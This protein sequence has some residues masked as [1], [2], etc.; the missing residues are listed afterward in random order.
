MTPT[1][2]T[3]RVLEIQRMSTEDGP[4]IRTTVF[5]KGCP[6]ACAW[7]HNPESIDPRPQIQWVESKCIGCKLCLAVCPQQALSD[8]A[9]GILIDR[10]RCTGCGACAD[11][12]PTTALELLGR[13]WTVDDLTNEVAKDKAFF[14]TSGG[15]VTASGGEATMNPQFVAAFFERLRALEIDTAL[16]TCGLTSLA[17]LEMILPH[18][19]ILLFDLK[20]ADEAAHRKFTGLSNRKIID[21]LHFVADFLQS[22][23]R[24]HTLWIRTPIIP[25]AT[26][27]AANLRRLG[28]LIAGSVGDLVARWEL[29]SFNNLCRDKYLRLGRVWDFHDTPLV[30]AET[31]EALAAIARSSGVD[32]TIVHWSGATRLENAA[33]APTKKSALP[34][35]C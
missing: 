25:D 12:C 7:C 15:G 4:G 22:H 30:R 32:P 14:A 35:S 10:D 6:L 11:E 21:S 9:G 31:M 28:E 26:D 5:F 18:T 13:A 24:P 1:D 20:L 17:N 3:A 23:D 29:C 33:L 16:D 27:S 34:R 19:D 8:G 2:A